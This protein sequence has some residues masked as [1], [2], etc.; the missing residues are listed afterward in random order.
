MAGVGNNDKCG[1][2]AAVN[3][4]GIA[5]LRVFGPY[6]RNSVYSLES[7]LRKNM[8]SISVYL[9]SWELSR[10]GTT[11]GKMPNSVMAAIQFGTEEGRN[12]LGSMYVIGSGS[13]G[14]NGDSCNYDSV[15]NSPY[16]FTV[17]SLG[18]SG[19]IA[20]YSERCDAV[21]VAAPGGDSEGG[22]VSADLVGAEGLSEGDCVDSSDGFFGPSAAA[23]YT[24]SV[25]AHILKAV[26]LLTW[27]D[28]QHVLVKSSSVVDVAQGGWGR[29]GANFNYSSAYG[30]HD[31]PGL[32]QYL[33]DS[34]LEL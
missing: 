28:V 1:V 15:T 2:G 23:A 30:M 11:L 14:E 3:S 24:S 19:K 25:I 10:S 4:V 13:G 34:C 8:D 17:G 7:A 32:L 31:N 6:P 26:P 29:N 33:S 5:S 12:G 16:T 21:L 20:T 18:K 9:N 27:R 22:L